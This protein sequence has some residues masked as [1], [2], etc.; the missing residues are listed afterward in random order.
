MFADLDRLERTRPRCSV[1]DKVQ[2]PTRERA[3]FK[4][5]FLAAS[6]QAKRRLSAFHEHG[7][8]H[9]TSKNRRA[10]TPAWRAKR[11]R[12]NARRRQ[13]LREQEVEEQ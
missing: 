4:A 12:A 9:L 13:R 7:S 11:A 5:V 1:C 2:Y 3:M 6:G 10:K 8:W